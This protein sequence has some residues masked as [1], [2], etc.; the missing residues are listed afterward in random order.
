MPES[1]RAEAE[2]L[3]GAR[4]FDCYSSEEVG[5]IALQC[6]D[7]AGYHLMSEMLLVEIV[8][9]DG[10]PCAPGEI[11]RVL[12]TDLRNFA[13]PLIRYELG[14]HAEMGAA[15]ACGRGLPVIR[16]VVGRERNLI[17]MPDGSRHWPLTA[18]S[19]YRSVAPVVQYQM[20]QQERERIEVRLV[21][22]T[23]LSADQE[24]SLKAMMLKALGYPFALDFVYFD[25][26]LPRGSNGK[27]EEFIC[28]V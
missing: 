10:E 23:P 18:R 3:W 17:L 1:L 15:C 5:Y 2:A 8:D 12:V 16:R 4:L 28:R 24:A 14:D 7:G 6:P 27:L 25:K 9:A 21:V 13:T 20:I 26:T 11:G 19:Q 22:E